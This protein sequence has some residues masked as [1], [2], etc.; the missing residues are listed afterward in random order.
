MM[1]LEL[2]P[3]VPPPC[4][5]DQRPVVCIFSEIDSLWVNLW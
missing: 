2:K 4:R 1:P 5:D 3:D